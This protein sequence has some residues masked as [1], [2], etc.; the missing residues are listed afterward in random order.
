MIE[1]CRRVFC[2]Q[3][4]F[5]RAVLSWSAAVLVEYLLLS[6]ALR[7]LDRLKGL[8]EMSP[9]RVLLFFLLGMVLLSLIACRA[10][11]AKTERWL[12]AGVLCV[13][14]A[15]SL[16]ASFTVPFLAACLLLLALS[17]IFGIFGWNSAEE[18]PAGPIRSRRVFVWITAVLA[19]VFFLFVSVWTV[20]RIYC[21]AVPTYDFGIF[22]QMFHSMKESG[23]P[24]TTLERDGL[25]SHFRVHVSPIWYLFLPFYMLIPLPATLQVMQ[26]AVMASA[27]IPL[28]KL[29]G[30]HGLSGTA[31]MLCCA[32]LLLYPA[33]SGGASYDVHENCF[34]TPLILWL[35]YGIDT[36]NTALIALS[37]FL[38]LAV[39]E[40]A[41]VYVAVIA[42]WLIVRGVLHFRRAERGTLITGVV[43]FAVSLVYF[44]LVTSFLAERGDGV[45]SYRYDNFI[46]DRSSSLITVIKAVLLNPMKA[47]Y[48]CADAEKLVFIAQTMLP[49]LGLP[50]MTRRYERYILLIPYVLVNLMSD[51]PYQYDIFFQYTFGSAAFLF[52]L[53][54][55]NVSEWRRSRR[56]IAAFAA[57]AVICGAG[58]CDLI[59]PK[60]IEYPRLCRVNGWLYED[61]WDTLALVPDG[62]SVTS[63]TFYTTALSRRNV[64]YD[65]GNCSRSQMLQTEYV[66][67]NVTAKSDYRHYARGQR[68]KGFAYLVEYLQKNGYTLYAELEGVLEIYR[69]AEQP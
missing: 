32:M 41:A 59:V 28:W 21:F 49:L 36:K 20:C 48:E 5:R 9:V 56:Q 27:V 34:L 17:V 12:L 25:L 3:S 42:L 60:A 13:L 19:V 10:D 57:A 22:A 8:G 16:R 46:Y 40:D 1:L 65:V 2:I 64:L 37:A 55:L 43:L 52:Y 50:L 30:H 51:Y 47:V 67:L 62:V 35:L 23:L 66:V 69:R 18:I 39:K 68:D 53:V 61:I 14:A 24:L 26:A 11:T 29:G 4:L 54:I 6:D 45:M 15:V 58:F 33:F 44:W 7:R 31:R 38:T 63:S